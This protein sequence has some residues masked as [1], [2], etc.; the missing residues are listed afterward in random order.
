MPE[1]VVA[2]R[3]HHAPVLARVGIGDRG[4]LGRR[5]RPARLGH[6]RR[7]QRALDHAGLR[8]R[9]Q[10]GPRQ[11]GLEELVGHAEPAAVVAVE[12]MVAAG[13]PEI[14]HGQAL[15]RC[16]AAASCARS[17]ASP[18]SSSP[19]TSRNENARIGLRSPRGCKR[20][21]RL[22]DRAVLELPA[23][24]DQR[25]RPD[26]RRAR[27]RTRPRPRP[28]RAR[29]RDRARRSRASSCCASSVD[30]R[31]AVGFARLDDLHQ[32]RPAQAFRAEKAAAEGRKRALP[33]EFCG[34]CGVFGEHERAG[35]RP[36]ARLGGALEHE[37][38]GRIE[39]DGAQKL[40]DFGPPVA[41]S[42]HDGDGQRGEQAQPLDPGLPGPPHQEIAVFGYF[43]CIRA[44]S[45]HAGSSSATSALPGSAT[46]PTATCAR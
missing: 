11:I 31:G 46:S 41:G 23:H 16:G 21:E 30:Q 4:D 28:R 29:R 42:N 9:L 7:V 1:Q 40:H 18:G 26:G 19:S 2:E 22:A 17:T 10:L 13:Q 33:D 27:P 25:V 38:V 45:R 15:C 44:C 20:A 14:P 36:F 39:P 43:P 37:G 34:V 6:Q 3:H 24:R 5:D 35:H 8:R 12:Q 32:R